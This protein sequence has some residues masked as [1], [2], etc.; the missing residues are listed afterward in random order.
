MGAAV[1]VR[2]L[3]RAF[4]IQFREPFAFSILF[5]E[6]WK[7]LEQIGALDFLTYHAHG[8]TP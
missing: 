7:S 4:L 2:F 8:L 1:V 3:P 6:C 5:R